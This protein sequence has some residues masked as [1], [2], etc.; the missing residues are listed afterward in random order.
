MKRSDIGTGII[1]MLLRS[2]LVT[3]FAIS[4]GRGIIPPLGVIPLSKLPFSDIIKTTPRIPYLIHV[5]EQSLH[6]LTLRTRYY[7]C[8][9]R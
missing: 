3:D 9:L 6:L 5:P 8:H 2:H 1:A 7:I 4:L